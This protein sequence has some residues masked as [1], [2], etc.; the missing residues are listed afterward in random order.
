M[1]A[2]RNG[3]MLLHEI[4]QRILNE[5]A[6][7]CF[8]LENADFAFTEKSALIFLLSDLIRTVL[9]LIRTIFALIFSKTLLILKQ[10]KGNFNHTKN[11]M[12]ISICSQ[13]DCILPW[14][15]S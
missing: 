9:L 13:T 8:A 12:N 2:I 4:I 15:T 1:L 7:L 5:S 10:I 11:K 14:N 6:K 3:R